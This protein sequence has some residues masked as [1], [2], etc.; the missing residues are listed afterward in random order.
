MSKDKSNRWEQGLEVVDQVYGPGSR[1]MMEGMQDHSFVAE[2]VEH[3]FGDVWADSKISIRDKRLMVLGLT[4]ML[5]R[6]DLFEIQIAGAIVNG[7]LTDEQLAE[8]PRFILFYA[9]AGNTTAM[10]RGIEAGKKRAQELMRDAKNTP[11][12]KTKPKTG[13]KA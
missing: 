12:G 8:I 7:E 5:G 13:K 3:Q 11:G 4:A 6:S 1:K 2:I 9:G 10:L